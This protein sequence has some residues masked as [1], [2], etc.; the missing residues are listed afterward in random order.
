MFGIYN[1]NDPWANMPEIPEE[2]L[3][4]VGPDDM[5]LIGCMHAFVTMVMLAIA[6]AICA[7]VVWIF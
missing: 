3:K 7:L 2:Q 4:D 5:H 1:P 6:L